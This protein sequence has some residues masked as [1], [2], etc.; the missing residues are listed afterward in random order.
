MS[1]MSGGEAPGTRRA[2]MVD[3]TDVR[4]DQAGLVPAV[5]QDATSAR[6]LMVA[7][8]DAEA[9]AATTATGVVHFHSRSRDE[10][11]RKG[12]TSGNVLH[13]RDI[14]LDCDG[15]TLLIRAAPAGPTCHRGTTSCFD[16]VEGSAG[17]AATG[18]EPQGFGWLEELWSTVR[19]R[20]AARPEG[21]YTAQLVAGGPDLAGRKVAEEAV[22]VL[23]AAKNDASPD[24]SSTET[25]EALAGE[26]ADLLYHL[27]VVLA[28]R[29]VPP[30]A[31]IGA[32]RE[33]H[34]P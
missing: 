6:V 33:R 22:E 14:A 21:S 10:L 19:A 34:L 32:L 11:W 30:A 3:P 25:R 13:L 9:L 7:W 17:S 27:L 8:M 15:D 26:A 20:A 24:G 18:A 31:V 5:V 2:A 23:I 16:P 29:D 12:S 28:E 4:W 1:A